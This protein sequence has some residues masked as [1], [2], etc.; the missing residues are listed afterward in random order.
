M[1]SLAFKLNLLHPPVSIF[2]KSV[3]L[4]SS[5]NFP[6][7]YVFMQLFSINII[8]RAAGRVP[9]VIDNDMM[10]SWLRHDAPVDECCYRAA[11]L[12]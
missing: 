12:S 11:G 6:G 7:W 4:Y 9:T 5:Y 10:E 1:V 8:Y 2:W 3:I